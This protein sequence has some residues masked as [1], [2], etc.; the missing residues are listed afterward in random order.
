MPSV[1]I[2]KMLSRMMTLVCVLGLS[3]I[4]TGCRGGVTALKK[5]S[6]VSTATQV[7]V[8][9]ARVNRTHQEHE[10]K[11]VHGAQ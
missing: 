10:N 9:I 5:M 11:Q 7:T 1:N 6:R 3:A 4:N 8:R 2:Q